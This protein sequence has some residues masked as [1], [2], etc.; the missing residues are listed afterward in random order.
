MVMAELA[1]F[2]L[3]PEGYVQ[4]LSGLLGHP[5]ETA[6]GLSQ[7]VAELEALWR[8]VVSL[9]GSMYRPKFNL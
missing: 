2:P 7:T 3:L 5:D 9:A 8:E 1:L 6:E 4:K